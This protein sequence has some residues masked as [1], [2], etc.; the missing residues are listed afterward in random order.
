MR[1][2]RLVAQANSGR[3]GGAARFSMR[4]IA[5]IVGLI[6]AALALA[7]VLLYSVFHVIAEVSG[8]AYDTVHVFWGLFLVLLAAVGAFLATLLPIAS[9][10]MLFVA[11]VGLFFVVGWWAVIAVPFLLV[12]AVMTFSNKRVALPGAE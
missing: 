11:A 12:A 8:I 6:G 9:A 3:G 1:K 2:G 7:I 5:T 4:V 10:I